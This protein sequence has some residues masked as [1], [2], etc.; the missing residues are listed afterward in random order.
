MKKDEDLRDLDRELSQLAAVQPSPE[1]A[2]KVRARIQQQPVSAFA[3]PRWTMASVAVAATIAIAIVTVMTVRKPPV[4]VLGDAGLQAGRAT[5]VHLP[6]Q[7]HPAPHEQTSTPVQDRVDR[8]RHVVRSER[9]VEPEVLIDPAVGRAVRRLA[10]E[11]PL[12][13]E[14]PPEPSLAPVV[15][16]PLRMPDIPDIGSVRLGPDLNR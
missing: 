13:P 2:A 15:V 5:D 1:F 4:P 8:V 6:Y 9:P 7:V 11:R 12:L 10:M 3:W 14:V 16:E